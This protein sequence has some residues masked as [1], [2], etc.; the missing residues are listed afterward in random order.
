[1]KPNKI[2]TVEMMPQQGERS[3]KTTEWNQKNGSVRQN[4]RMELQDR[5]AE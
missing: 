1:M 3:H 5:A 4:Y 2:V